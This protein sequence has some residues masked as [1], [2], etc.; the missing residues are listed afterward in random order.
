VTFAALA[1]REKRK[2]KMSTAVTPVVKLSL[3][4]RIEQASLEAAQVAA[5][6]SP[7]IGAAIAAGASME[8]V[9]SGFLH[10][11]IGIF[12]HHAAKA[13]PTLAPVA[14][15]SLADAIRKAQMRR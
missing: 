6:F 10:T 3:E 9:V 4:Q 2:Q 8:P 7:A 11:L 14:S 15:T 12:R 5:T 1:Q 13:A